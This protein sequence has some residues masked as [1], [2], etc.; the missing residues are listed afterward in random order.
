MTPKK[1]QLGKTIAPAGAP[2]APTDEARGG[3]LD[4]YD[5]IRAAQQ[6]PGGQPVQRPIMPVNDAPVAP[7]APVPLP[8]T[9]FRNGTVPPPLSWPEPLPARPAPAPEPTRP[10]LP[11]QI[12]PRQ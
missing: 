8:G 6:G 2:A 11:P 9:P 3:A 5:L 1:P 12:D 4:R 10:D 7:A